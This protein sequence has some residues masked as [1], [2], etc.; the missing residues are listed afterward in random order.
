MGLRSAAGLLANGPTIRAFPAS[1][2]TSGVTAD[3]V[4]DHSGGSAPDSHRLPI[5]T[6]LERADRSAGRYGGSPGARHGL[7]DRP[8]DKSDDLELSRRAQVTDFHRPIRP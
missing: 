2:L 7:S 4:P 6:D 5:A 3:G 1:V 8:R